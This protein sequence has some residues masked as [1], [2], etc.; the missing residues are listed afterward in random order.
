MIYRLWIFAAAILPAFGSR[1]DFYDAI[2][3]DGLAGAWLSP[4]F[5]NNSVARDLSGGGLNLMASGGVTYVSGSV[6]LDATNKA[7]I[8]AT[9]TDISN[10]GTGE[11]VIIVKTPTNSAVPSAISWTDRQNDANFAIFRQNVTSQQI[12]VQRST[13]ALPMILTSYFL[14]TG[15]WNVLGFYS[16]G[17]TNRMWRHTGIDAPNFVQ[18]VTNVG[19][20]ISFPNNTNAIDT[21]SIGALARPSP[22]FYDGNFAFV[23]VWR[24]ILTTSERANFY[25][26]AQPM[27]RSLP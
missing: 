12:L 26:R 20:F 6:Y 24:R 25:F 27:I 22:G 8:G 1:A 4:A 16:D 13:Q 7:Y 2:P 18:Q 11:V 5:A 17:T 3:K 23:G 15:V 9:T 10:I 19:W 14:T 21:L